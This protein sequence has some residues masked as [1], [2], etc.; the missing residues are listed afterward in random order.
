MQVSLQANDANETGK[1]KWAALNSA[2]LWFFV[3][4]LLCICVI[5]LV[6]ALLF[7]FMLLRE[8]ALAAKDL[9]RRKKEDARASRAKTTLL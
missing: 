9:V 5:G 8:S 4:T 3:A 2:S 1:K 7:V 6:I